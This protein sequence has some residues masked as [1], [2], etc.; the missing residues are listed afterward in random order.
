MPANGPYRLGMAPQISISSPEDPSGQ[1]ELRLHFFAG[2]WMHNI[3]IPHHARGY[4]DL[5]TRLNSAQVST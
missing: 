1:C 2:P 4:R 3:E 5:G